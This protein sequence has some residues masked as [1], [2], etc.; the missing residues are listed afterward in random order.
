MRF[1]WNDEKDRQ[2][3]LK[4]GVRF[5]TAALVFDDPCALTQ[6]DDA[7]SD[8]VRWITV[9]SA[10]LDAVLFVVH[11]SL[12]QDGEET[13]RII[14]ARAATPRERRSYEEAKQDTKTRHRHHPSHERRG[15]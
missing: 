2:N 4:H 3:L 10:S 15:H 6:H 13:T 5:E 9:G 11:T 1:E 7:A 12:E 14:S 8:D